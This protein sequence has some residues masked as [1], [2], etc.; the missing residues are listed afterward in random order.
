MLK[1]Q[2]TMTITWFICVLGFDYTFYT[3][4]VIKHI[5]YGPLYDPD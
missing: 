3:H 2:Y 4:K 1:K 5:Q